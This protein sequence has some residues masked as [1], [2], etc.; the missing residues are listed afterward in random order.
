MTFKAPVPREIVDPEA[1]R[2]GPKMEV[3]VGCLDVGGGCSARDEGS[4]GMK[5]L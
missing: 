2:P 4:E 5:E 1:I 3:E